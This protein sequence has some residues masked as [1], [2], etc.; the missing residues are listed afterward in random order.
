MFD[1]IAP[2]YDKLNHILSFGMDLLWR[3]KLAEMIDK[4]RQLRILDL[5][6]G[7]GDLLIALL[8][9]NPNIV[10]AIGLDISE[11]M[12]D[13]CRKKISH[14]NLTS[15]VNLI[16]DDVCSSTVSDNSFDFVT[17][18]FGIRN[19][20]DVSKTL[21]EI[22]RLLKPHGETLILEFSIP[23]NR[24]FRYLYLLYL[25]YYVPFIG[26]LISGDKEAYGYL[27]TSIEK[28]CKKEELS[29]LMNKIGFE[30]IISSPLSFGIAPRKVESDFFLIIIKTPCFMFDV[31]RDV[32]ACFLLL[33][34]VE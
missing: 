33:N 9:K 18:A 17:M 25:R 14:H 23:S 31:I 16:C 15:K 21:S 2:S 30:N 20:P 11:N 24:A 28:F 34:L 7:T 6:T 13:I 8:R 19:T 4:Q 1:R 32:F 22:L 5:A 10:E 27:N 26:R 12:L 3:R 29:A